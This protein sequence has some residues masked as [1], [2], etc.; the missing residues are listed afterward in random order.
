MTP[1]RAEVTAE[2]VA[3]CPSYLGM[4]DEPEELPV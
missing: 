4:V 1:D 3:A 2:V